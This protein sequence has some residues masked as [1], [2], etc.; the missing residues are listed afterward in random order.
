MNKKLQEKALSDLIAADEATGLYETPK[1]DILKTFI[2]RMQ[3]IGIQV[4]LSGNY[5]WIYIDKIN[6]KR[7]TERF[8]GNHGFTIAF[9]PIRADRQMEF[10]DITE[11]FKLIRKYVT[12]G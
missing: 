1:R 12:V 8:K 11:L 3:R 4:Q 6:G 5:P 2:D 9:S 7:V 10:T